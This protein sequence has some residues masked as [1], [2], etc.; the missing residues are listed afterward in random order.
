MHSGFFSYSIKL[1][2]LPL[3]AVTISLHYNGVASP[4]FGGAKMF[5]FRQATVF[6]FGTPFLKAQNDWIC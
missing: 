5:D 6:L 1:R 2:G 3:S 4:N